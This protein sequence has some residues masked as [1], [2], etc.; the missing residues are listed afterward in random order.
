MS[1]IPLLTEEQLVALETRFPP[2]CF[3]GANKESLH[4]HL[5]YAGKVDLIRTLRAHAEN[6]K[7]SLSEAVL[8]A[9]LGATTKEGDTMTWE[10]IG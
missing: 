1:D 5:V 6:H 10:E 9:A 2:R 3:L 4:A 7:A 8:P